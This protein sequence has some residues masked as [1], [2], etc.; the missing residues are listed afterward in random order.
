V[1]NPITT[2]P[3]IT[4]TATGLIPTLQITVVVIFTLTFR[5]AVHNVV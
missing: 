1:P 4:Y 3:E 5:A 2:T